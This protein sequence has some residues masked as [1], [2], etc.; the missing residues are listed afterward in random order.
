MSITPDLINEQDVD[1]TANVNVDGSRAAHAKPINAKP[2]RMMDAVVI[3]GVL[4]VLGFGLYKLLPL[5]GINVLGLLASPPQA[6]SMNRVQTQSDAQAVVEPA[7][8]AAATAGS[9]NA[10]RDQPP[11]I[12]TG[13]PNFTIRD[14]MEHSFITDLDNQTLKRLDQLDGTVS[15]IVG[16]TDQMGQAVKA[17]AGGIYQRMSA[18]EQQQK[19]LQATFE[20]TNQ[21]LANLRLEI[22][23]LRATVTRYRGD[24]PAALPKGKRVRGWS[25]NAVNGDRAW[26]KTQSG[27]VVSVISGDRL[28]KL[29]AVNRVDSRRKLVV[30]SDGRY[31]R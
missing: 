17:M 28:K 16:Y 26:L 20:Q 6:I 4:A 11:V 10:M 23:D 21:L 5:F 18:V 15:Q 13:K 12:T 24:M 29:G 19:S 25:V 22:G 31:I 3:V 27:K 8:V 1:A 9:G 14:G 7:V 30:L 2:G